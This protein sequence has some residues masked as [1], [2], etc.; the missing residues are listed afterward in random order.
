M[1]RVAAFKWL[2]SL[3]AEHFG[4]NKYEDGPTE[5]SAQ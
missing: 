2:R 1:R 3:L 5:T 4:H